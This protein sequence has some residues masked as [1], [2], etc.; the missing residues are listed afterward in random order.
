MNNIR[1]KDIPIYVLLILLPISI[2][3][4]SSV[5]LLNV[6]LIDIFFIVYII[7]KKDFSSLKENAVKLL[8][9]LFVYLIINTFISHDP[10]LSLIH[11]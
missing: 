10:G 4:G 11:I 9:I 5:S 1:Y 7:L 3:L 6:L 8:L 2:V